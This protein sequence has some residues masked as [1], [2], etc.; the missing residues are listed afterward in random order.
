MD[1][2]VTRLRDQ[3]RDAFARHYSLGMFKLCADAADEIERLRASCGEGGC[4]RKCGEANDSAGSGIDRN[5]EDT[6]Q[7]DRP[8]AMV[9]V[10]PQE[11]LFAAAKR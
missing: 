3:G 11:D 4:P 6:T 7:G 1:D 9:K 8:A 10:P 5:C 2:I